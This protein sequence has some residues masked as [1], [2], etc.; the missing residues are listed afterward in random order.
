MAW[1]RGWSMPHGHPRRKRVHGE[2]FRPLRCPARPN[3]PPYSIH[4]LAQTSLTTPHAPKRRRRRDLLPVANPPFYRFLGASA[5]IPYFLFFLYSISIIQTKFKLLFWT[6]DFKCQTKVYM[7]YAYTVWNNIIYL[8]LLS[9]NYNVYSFL[10]LLFS[11][12]FY[13]QILIFKLKLVSWI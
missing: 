6:L 13:F 10:F 5:W 3:Y 4:T 12:L 1:W 2:L 8:L 7:N 9:Y 11:F